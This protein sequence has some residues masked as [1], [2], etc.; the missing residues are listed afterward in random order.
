MPVPLPQLDDRDFDSL[1]EETR[2]LIARY[3]PEWTNHNPSDAGVTLLELFAWL[4]EQTIYRS[5]L[6]PLRNY[7]TFLRLLGLT[8]PADYTTLEE[9]IGKAQAILRERY[10]A[11]T[12]D[13]YVDLTMKKMEA[14]QSGLAGRVIVLNNI[15]LEN[16]P[17]PLVALSQIERR[18]HVTVVVIPRRLS[19]SLYVDPTQAPLPAP[20]T[21]LLNEIEALLKERCVI[22]T[23]IHAVGPRYVRVNA[24]AFVF[25]KPQTERTS[26]AARI[27]ASIRAFFDPIDGGPDGQGWPAGR[28]L[29]RSEFYKLLED[30]PDV[31]HVDRVRFTVDDE[32]Q[33]A[34]VEVQ[35][36]QT[37]A[38][39]V[40]TVNFVDL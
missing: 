17:D 34:D 9:G 26:A 1:F 7:A 36:W 30:D 11:V 25:A 39:G 3:N 2:A 5:N 14:L 23:R 32:E 15:N 33:P 22:T 38:I 21:L 37:I 20:S 4:V 35:L 28:A 16:P 31:D 13:D 27:A 6:L 24:E 29:Y 18:G 19:G 10:R 12:V 40:A 8:S